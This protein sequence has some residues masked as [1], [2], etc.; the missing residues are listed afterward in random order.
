MY[1]YLLINSNLFFSYNDENKFEYTLLC[2]SNMNYKIQIQEDYI[3][4]PEYKFNFDL[5]NSIDYKKRKC[6]ALYDMKTILL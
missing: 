5:L 1:I 3:V 6:S 4:K 2:T